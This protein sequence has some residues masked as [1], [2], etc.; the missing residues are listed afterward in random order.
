MNRSSDDREAE[1]RVQRSRAR[2][3]AGGA[4][5][6]LALTLTLA[7]CFGSGGSSSSGGL[8]GSDPA[9]VLPAS[10]L[11]YAQAVVRPTGSLASD[12]DA[13]SKR[14]LGIA[15]PGQQLDALIDKSAHGLSYEK[16]IRPW[17][18][19]RVGFALLNAGKGGTGYAAVIDQTDTAKAQAA[20][21]SNVF[22]QSN[23]SG[24][25]KT[26]TGSYR[27][28][29]YTNHVT[30]GALV[31][32]VGQYVVVANNAAAFDAIVDVDKGASSLASVG[33]YQQALS[34]DLP[35]A[36]G[37]AYVP[38]RKLIDLIPASL[39]SSSEQAV[40]STVKGKI[41]NEI[42]HGSASFD[43]RGALFDLGALDAPAPSGSSGAS[44][45]STPE[46]NPI[47]SLP[48]DSW[49]AIG[50]THI[51]PALLSGIGEL[52]KIGGSSSAGSLSASLSEIQLATGVDV[53]SD[54][55]AMT[56]AGFFVSGTSTSTVNVAL[57][58]GLDDASKA[59]PIVGQIYKLATLIQGT[60]KGVSVSSLSQGST[61]SFTITISGLPRPIVI[62]ASG[63]HIIVAYGQSSLSAATSS[64]AT[65]ANSSG[66]KSASALLGSGIQPVAYVNIAA[67]GN[68]AQSAVSSS[69]SSAVTELERLGS[70]AI[71]AGKIGGNS[72]VRFAIAGS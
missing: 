29:S 47:G 2:R 68:V 40:F 5:A 1:P 37:M 72:H 24:P 60:Q 66:F 44:V 15:D 19:A 62:A 7:G 58:L 16:D 25:G 46:T 31:G 71:G 69:S 22:Y 4:L 54:L 26:T 48:A 45:P 3:R 13:A 35:H 49:F 14:L 30:A 59:Q 36:A 28:V 41:G 34:A 11:A 9:S 23:G 21:T 70:V 38:V 6:A 55:N 61:S 32:V 33:T 17:L 67:L 65:L 63:G 43:A 10:T 18:G 57:V 39:P 27:G 42:L 56:T 52:A 51:G 64:G 12:I 53:R 20:V 50:A 8:P